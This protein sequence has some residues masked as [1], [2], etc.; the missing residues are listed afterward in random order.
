MNRS[1]VD[2]FEKLTGQLISTYDELSILSK[3]SPGDAVNKFKLK[4]VNSLLVEANDYLADKYKPFSEFD[5]FDED[6]VPQNSDVVFIL[7]QYI[8]CFEKLRADNV[9][10]RNGAWYWRLNAEGDE[11]GDDNGKVWIRTIK[12]KNLKE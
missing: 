5:S 10:M 1:D 4:F 12:P 6:D 9:S 3:K 11:Q 2:I 8:Q 7:G